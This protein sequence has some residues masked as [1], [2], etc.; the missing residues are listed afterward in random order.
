LGRKGLFKDRKGSTSSAIAFLL[1][2]I[3]LLIYTRVASTPKGSEEAFFTVYGFYKW[4]AQV[5]GLGKYVD[6]YLKGFEEFL[7]YVQGTFLWPLTVSILALVVMELSMLAVFCGTWATVGTTARVLGWV[8]GVR[9]RRRQEKLVEEKSGIGLVGIVA[10]LRKRLKWSQK[11]SASPSSGQSKIRKITKKLEQWRRQLLTEW[12][13]FHENQLITLKEG[14][15]KQ[16]I[17]EAK[18]LFP[19]DNAPNGSITE[20]AN[21]SGIDSA[22]LSRAMN[23]KDYSMTVKN[24]ER[25]LSILGMPYNKLTPYIKSIGGGG[26][27]ESITHPKLPFDL[28]N[29]DGARLV[30]AALKDGHIRKERKSFEYTNYNKEN[31][32]RVIESVNH[33]FGE[34]KYQ[35]RYDENGRQKGVLFH[36]GAIGLAIHRAGVPEGKKTMQDFPAPDLIKYGN[37][38]IK[39]EYFQQAI[40]DEGHIDHRSYVISM[41]NAQDIILRISQQCLDI[42]KRQTW[43]K[44]P[45]VSGVIVHYLELN[46]DLLW[47]LPPEQRPIYNDFL[48]KMSREWIPSILKD[49]RKILEE[50]YGVKV[51][52][53]P[54][55]VYKGEKGGLK[56]Y[57]IIEVR[58]KANY[59]KLI[60]N[61]GPIDKEGDESKR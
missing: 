46:D 2:I 59:K 15:L 33:V 60:K 38:S 23:Q 5:L 35:M 27:K 43:D 11:D 51:D 7:K 24:L 25:L 1:T 55:Q 17:Q 41:S 22:I 54:R 16:L 6:K 32:H 52:I 56:G 40:R 10:A 9:V 8:S 13:D 34:V 57:W 44:R 4:L 50:T 45:L 61:L 58:G 37:L 19:T 36:S 53:K 3:V 14:K 29:P 30:A 31:V 39:N 48:S 28:Y 42:F 20:L 47:R 18:K 49:E 26:F 21:R 12:W